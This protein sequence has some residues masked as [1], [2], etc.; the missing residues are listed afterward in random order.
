LKNTLR[1]GAYVFSASPDTGLFSILFIECKLTAR[2]YKI[3]YRNLVMIYMD[4]HENLT[5][6]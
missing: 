3:R 5:Q 2:I 4:E 6:A 1:A